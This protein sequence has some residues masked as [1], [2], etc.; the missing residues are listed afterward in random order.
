MQEHIELAL[1]PANE[2]WMWDW[3]A[4]DLSFYHYLLPFLGSLILSLIC[5]L[6]I[7]VVNIVMIR[8]RFHKHDR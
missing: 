1:S 4:G 5:L 2:V 3:A 6:S 8:R 7:I